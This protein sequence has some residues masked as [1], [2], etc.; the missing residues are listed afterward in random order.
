MDISA[1]R[2][3]GKHRPGQFV[4]LRI[5]E[6]GER[7]LSRSLILTGKK[8][9]YYD[10]LPGNGKKQPHNCQLLKKGMISLIS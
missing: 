2:I 5:D 6:T 8:E 10:D 4:I 7:I 3:A 9:T 1:P